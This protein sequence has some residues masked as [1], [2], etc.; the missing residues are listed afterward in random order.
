MMTISLLAAVLMYQRKGSYGSIVRNLSMTTW[1]ISFLG[2]LTGMVWAQIAWGKYWSFDPKETM[3]L[4]Y[5]IDLSCLVYASY[6]RYPRKRLLYLGVLSTLL[7]ALTV[8]IPFVS[9]SL[10]SF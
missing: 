4:L 8:L 9:L 1:V 5:F 2:L 3:T 7:M 6:K 10:H